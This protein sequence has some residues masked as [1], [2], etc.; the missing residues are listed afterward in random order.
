[1]FGFEFLA[2]VAP[3]LA[4]RG[5]RGRSVSARPVSECANPVSGQEISPGVRIWY[6]PH[7]SET[8][9]GH[10]ATTTADDAAEFA[11][12]RDAAV[13]R[14]SLTTRAMLR[15]ALSE[16]VGGTVAPHA[17]RFGRTE[18]GKP[19]L[20]NGPD[21]LS[22][23]CSHTEVASIIVVSAS[24]EVGVDIEAAAIPATEHWLADVFTKTERAAINAL[25][26]HERERT[27]ARLW[28]LKESYLKMLGT[29]IADLLEVAF[30]PRNDCLL[31]GHMSRQAAASFQTWIV[32][33]QGQLLSVA[34]A[35]RDPKKK[36]A[37]WRQLIGECRGRSRAKFVSDDNRAPS[38]AAVAASL[39]RGAGSAAT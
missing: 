27:V 16:M 15:S 29:G 7:R 34:V 2:S 30:D 33:C 21:T 17:W 8:G 4:Y 39:F 12:I 18:N 6:V 23:S 9:A 32:N 3:I 25:P 10:C 5:E 38:G 31:P 26:A 36:G 24:K 1:M 19:V 35:I 11:G 22:F 13:R 14:R 37:F 20:T 28:T